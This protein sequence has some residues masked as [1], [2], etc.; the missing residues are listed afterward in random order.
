MPID[1]NMLSNAIQAQSQSN[2]R[3]LRNS[4]LGPS[5]AAAQLAA[6]YNATQNLGTG[7]LQGWHANNQE[8]N[9]VLG[10][11]NNNEA[12]RANF[13]ATLDQARAQALNQAKYQNLQNR[14]Y[15]AKC[16]SI[17]ACVTPGGVAIVGMWTLPKVNSKLHFSAIFTLF[18]SAPLM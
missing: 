5:L 18:S 1:M 7:L 10:A 15:V 14:L 9:R 3:A 6:D 16:D 13:Y 8:R 4:G 11:N 2:Q 12:Q 17:A